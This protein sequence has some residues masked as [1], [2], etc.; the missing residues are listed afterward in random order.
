[1]RNQSLPKNPLTTDQYDYQV[2]QEPLFN[3]DGKPVM[4]GKS[5]IMGNFRTDNKVCLGTSTEKY[6]IVNNGRIVEAVDEALSAL[7]ITDYKTDMRVAADGARFYGVYDFPSVIKPIAK[8]DAAGMRI[9][10]RNSFDRSCGVNWQI[11]IK[12][13][14]CLNGMMSLVTDTSLSKRH[15]VKLTLDFMK[16]AIKECELKFEASVKGL[17]VLTEKPVSE[18]QGSL[19]LDNLA[20][21]QVLSEQ[22]KDS[23]VCEWLNPSRDNTVN[24]DFDRNLY[25]V[26]NA[27]TWVLASGRNDNATENKRFEQARRTSTNVLRHLTKAAEK[28]SHFATL[29]APVPV[30]EKVAEV[31]TL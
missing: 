8:G 1:M 17:Q 29:T 25:N 7:N 14:V 28:D 10:L 18:D 31:V 6:E 9:T 26:Y 12:R 27:A 24:G 20:I 13:L 3:R 21:K 16:D 22:M 15:S 2:V 23:I 11:G 19:I 4:V 30:K 5:P